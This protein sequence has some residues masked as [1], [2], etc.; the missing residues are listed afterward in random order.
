MLSYNVLV[1]S[2]DV[3]LCLFSPKLELCLKTG[4]VWNMLGDVK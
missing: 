4:K 3:T 2:L 1:F